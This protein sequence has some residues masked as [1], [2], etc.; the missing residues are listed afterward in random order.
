[1]HAV[2]APTGNETRKQFA[3]KGLIL[4]GQRSFVGA[5]PKRDFILARERLGCEPLPHPR[6]FQPMEKEAHFAGRA[7]AHFHSAP[8]IGRNE[9]HQTRSRHR[10]T[11]DGGSCGESV[12]QTGIEV[13]GVAKIDRREFLGTLVQGKE[14]ELGGAVIGYARPG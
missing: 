6:K 2:W 1:M 11:L 9:T 10:T 13:P 7:G 5:R 12:Q 14:L 3:A 4:R 8:G